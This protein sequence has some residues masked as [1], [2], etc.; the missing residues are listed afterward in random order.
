M[1]KKTLNSRKHF[2]L[3]TARR[4]MNASMLTLFPCLVSYN[5]KHNNK[6]LNCIVKTFYLDL[7]VQTIPLLV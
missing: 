2:S 4:P 1:K 5:L 6:Q 3:S 7:L